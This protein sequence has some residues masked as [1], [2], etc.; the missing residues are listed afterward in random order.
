MNENSDSCIFR[1][2]M[3]VGLY[4]AQIGVS[5]IVTRES[6]VLKAPGRSYVIA[7]EHLQ[8]LS[9]TSLLGLFKRGIRI[10]HQQP[11]LPAAVVFYPSMDRDLVRQRMSEFGWA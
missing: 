8:Y 4:T 3:R 11:G 9:D 1:G 7:R 6:I 5:M 10:S 2:S